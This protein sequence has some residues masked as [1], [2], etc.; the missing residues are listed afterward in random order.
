[1]P[2]KR[3][4][5]LGDTVSTVPGRIIGSW[6]WLIDQRRLIPETLNLSINYAQLALNWF[7]ED[8]L[9]DAVIVSGIIVPRSG[10]QLLIIITAKSGQT[11]NHY[12]NLW[13]FTGNAS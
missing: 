2:E 10:I 7:I 1:M 13:E 5:W 8:E 3:R 11:S 12:R 6:L 9:A 4:G